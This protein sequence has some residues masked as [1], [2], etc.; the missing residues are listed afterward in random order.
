MKRYHFTIVLLL[1]LSQIGYGQSK[2]YMTYFYD[3]GEK[4]SE[5]WL[6]D[7]KPNGYWKTF[8]VNGNVKSEGNRKF[9]ELDSLWKFYNQ[10]GIISMEISYLSGLKDGKKSLYS[11]KGK[12]LSVSNFQ[13]MLR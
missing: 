9:Y 3:T 11:D 5:G 6:E 4:L 13:V 12:L 1:L 2:K 10:D 8:Y 7:G